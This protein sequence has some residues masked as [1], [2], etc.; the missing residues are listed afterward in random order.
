MNKENERIRSKP[1]QKEKIIVDIQR[2]CLLRGDIQL[3]FFHRAS[4]R[5]DFARILKSGYLKPIEV[6]N[7]TFSNYPYIC[8]FRLS[9][10]TAFVGRE[11]NEIISKQ[12]SE[13]RAVLA[14][15]LGESYDGEDGS[16][17]WTLCK[18]ELDAMF[19]GPAH[20]KMLPDHF[21]IKFIFSEPTETAMPGPPSSTLASNSAPSLHNSFGSRS[22]ADLPPEPST[23]G[24]TPVVDGLAL[25]PRGE[26]APKKQTEM[27]TTKEPNR[28]ARATISF[29]RQKPKE[30]RS[31]ANTG[32]VQFGPKSSGPSDERSNEESKRPYS[33]RMLSRRS[34]L[35]DN[36]PT[37]GNSQAQFSSA[38]IL[39]DQSVLA[40]L[41]SPLLA[42]PTSM[43]LAPCFQLSVAPTLPNECPSIMLT[44]AENH[45]PQTYTQVP[46]YPFTGES[47]L[48][49]QSAHL[50]QRKSGVPMLHPPLSPS[51]SCAPPINGGNRMVDFQLPPVC[52]PQVLSS[53]RTD[54]AQRE[55]LRQ[56]I[57]QER[58]RAMQQNPLQLSP[59]QYEQQYEPAPPRAKHYPP[60][61]NNVGRGEDGV[62]RGR[63]RENEKYFATNMRRTMEH[64]EQQRK[65]AEDKQNASR[66]GTTGRGRGAMGQEGDSSAPRRTYRISDLL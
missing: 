29:D 51:P 58:L 39:S 38:D 63:D 40:P 35:H 17:V 2:G 37:P 31:P 59:R 43:T 26:S 52:F 3:K 13:N 8:L 46:R 18:E 49:Y 64:E 28:R 61:W 65:E 62:I 5:I 42:Q 12:D 41:H 36:R 25:S 32:S 34:S 6:L 33:E 56:Q 48:G 55:R 14:R 57:M 54:E 27:A 21:S 50:G 10:H 16:I 53:P 7:T 9:F 30:V 60:D 23:S 45:H 22:T 47:P 20:T 11:L 1:K 24:F 4:S 66:T 19:S 44:S 15:S